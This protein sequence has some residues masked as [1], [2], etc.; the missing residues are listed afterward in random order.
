VYTGP[1]EALLSQELPASAK[2]TVDAH[3]AVVLQ[4]VEE[5]PE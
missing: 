1:T 2:F 4:A 3:A 5:T